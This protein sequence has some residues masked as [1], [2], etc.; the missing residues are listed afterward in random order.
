[1][2]ERAHPVDLAP[3]LLAEV[4]A[5]RRLEPA[6]AWE[7]LRPS[8]GTLSRCSSPAEQGTLWRL[9]GH[10]MRALGRAGDA[11][12][13]YRQAERRFAIAA[14]SGERGRCAI[15]LVDALMYL[16]RYQDARRAAAA[17]RRALAH[18]GDRA[19]LARLRMNE[20][21]LH[22]RVDRPDRALECYRDSRRALLATR[23]RAGV[24]LVEVNIANCLSALGRGR[25]A[26]RYYRASRDRLLARGDAVNALV[27]SYNLSYLDFLEHR[28]ERAL[29][30]LAE[31]RRQAVARGALSIVPLT[32]LDRAE[33][34][35]RLGAHHD[36][37]AEARLASVE[38]RAM[39][40]AYEHAKA[41]LF[42]ALAE[43]RSGRSASAHARL[44]RSLGAFDREGNDLWVGETLV[45]LATTVWTEHGSRGAV[46]LLAAA[47]RRFELAS[48]P[49]RAACALALR[50]RAQVVAGET[51]AARTT[52]NAA[53]L[54][55]RRRN[56]PREQ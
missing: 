9:R 31:V 35:L 12:A 6:R 5:V 45:G 20:G 56:S 36:A 51:R 54:L 13:A 1:M 48:D 7:L 37:L 53:T 50:A 4:E 43:H 25:E 32:A 15:G 28:H 8:F 47:A 3:Q 26:R 10:L 19:A 30:G 55:A 52:M 24:E 11:V 39:G 16:G 38:A 27:A 41:E 21:N 23:Q 2:I 44:E 34:F 17:G 46:A 18:A 49:E 14:D 29:E 40:L 22:H 33:V 42:A